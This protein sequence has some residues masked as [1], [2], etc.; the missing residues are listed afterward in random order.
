MGKYLCILSVCISS[1]DMIRNV[2]V[3]KHKEL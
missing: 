2:K 1:I 3:I